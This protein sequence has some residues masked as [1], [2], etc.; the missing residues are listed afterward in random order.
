MKKILFLLPALSFIWSATIFAQVIE[1]EDYQVFGKDTVYPLKDG[2]FL[3]NERI[4][5]QNSPYL[6]LAYGAGYN[7]KK[8]SIE[9]NLIISYHHFIRNVGLGIGYHT[10]SD[11][12]VWWR[13]FQKQNDLFLAGGWRLEGLR[14]NLG[15]FAGPS[16]AYG[17]YIAWSDERGE[18]RAYGFTTL[19][20]MAEIQLTYRIFYDIGV[21][22]SLY[23]SYNKYYAVT[24]AQFHLFFSTAYIR[25]Y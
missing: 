8:S 10:S 16:L 7:H 5:K 9:Q 13:S 24:G 23:G 12:Q 11:I 18:N 4:Y 14:Y 22:L 1:G 3:L 25:D 19:G 20:G 6:T 17:S 2:R 21:G 15:I